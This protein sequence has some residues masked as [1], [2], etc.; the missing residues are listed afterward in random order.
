MPFTTSQARQDT[1][2]F[3]SKALLIPGNRTWAI[4][5]EMIRLWKL[6]RRWTTADKIYNEFVFDTELNEFLIELQNKSPLCGWNDVCSASH[7][8]WQVFFQLEVMPYEL[9]KR[10]ENGEVE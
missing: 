1:L 9:E 8:A 3:P 5:R 2:E 7:L 6:E 10:S 4:Y